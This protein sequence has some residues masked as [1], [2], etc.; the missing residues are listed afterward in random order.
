MPDRWEGIVMQQAWEDLA[1]QYEEA[2]GSEADDH[3]LA[4]ILRLKMIEVE[5]R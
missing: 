4:E 1:D 3:T 5:G 2:G